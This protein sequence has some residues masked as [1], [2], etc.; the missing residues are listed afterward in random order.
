MRFT[1]LALSAMIFAI[2]LAATA[3]PMP[4]AE[5][6]H[7]MHGMLTP[8]QRMMWHEQ[9]RAQTDAMTQDQRHAFFQQQMQQLMAMTPDQQAKLRDDLQARWNA[10][11]PDQQQ[12]MEQRIAQRRAQW[13]QR[14]QNGAAPQGNSGNE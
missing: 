14:R 1:T 10:L 5:Q 12:A 13:Q 6:G 11:P 7:G 3:Q 4:P 9:A 8:E 2:P